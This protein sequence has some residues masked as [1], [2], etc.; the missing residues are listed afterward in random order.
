MGAAVLPFWRQALP[1]F[2]ELV[3]LNLTTSSGFL[4]QSTG[5]NALS[6]SG[7][8]TA[9]WAGGSAG[10][11]LAAD[12]ANQTLR[13]QQNGEFVTLQVPGYQAAAK[14]AS[15]GAVII[16]TAGTVLPAAIRPAVD[17]TSK[18]R[19]YDN[20]AFASGAGMCIV[21]T[22]GQLEIYLDG[23]A[24][25]NYTVTN[26]IGFDTFTVSYRVAAAPV[27]AGTFQLLNGDTYPVIE[28]NIV[29][30]AAA[31]TT[32]RVFLLV[33]LKPETRPVEYGV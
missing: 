26:G 28:P 16:L 29:L 8:H 21:K 9:V 3:S 12:S 5:D 14:G 22:T 13:Y 33:G 20:G 30:P 31:P 24:T 19:K 27:A 1:N 25:T 15:P 32:L 23:S 7:A 6:A 10:T 4:I 11:A 18:T 2:E 17:N